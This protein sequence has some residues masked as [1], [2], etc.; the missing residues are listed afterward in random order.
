MG[1]SHYGRRAIKRLKRL[2]LWDDLDEANLSKKAARR[3]AK[4]EIEEEWRA[5]ELAEDTVLKTAGCKSLG[6]SILPPSAD[7]NL[8]PECGTQNYRN[9]MEC[10][11]C[12]Y[13]AFGFGR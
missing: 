13:E 8:C 2:S 11:L 7:D 6:S 1:W 3:E 4:E 10:D 12:N 9:T 5:S